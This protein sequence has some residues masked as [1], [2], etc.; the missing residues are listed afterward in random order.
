MKI[1]GND[2]GISENIGVILMVSV[3]VIG[4]AIVS[5]TV[6]SE[7]APEEIPNAD[8]IIGCENA[9]GGTFNVTLYHNGGD[10]LMPDD[11]VV[12]AYD[13][14]DQLIENVTLYEGEST[15]PFAV[16]DTLTFRTDTRPKRISVLYTGGASSAALKSL[17]IGSTVEDDQAAQESASVDTTAS[18][19]ATPTG[20]GEPTPTQTV[21]PGPYP[22]GSAI[23]GDSIWLNGPKKPSILVHGTYIKFRYVQTSAPS[24]ITFTDGTSIVPDNNDIIKIAMEG[25]QTTGKIELAFD[26]VK[27][28]TKGFTAKVYRNNMSV[29]EY[30]GKIST[31]QIQDFT[32]YESTLTLMMPALKEETQLT[33]DGVQII[34]SWPHNTSAIN[35]Y[36][37]GP[38]IGQHAY[39][40]LPGPE[41]EPSQAKVSGYYEIIP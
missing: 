25:T 28:E 10:T 41:G 7:P 21:T 1:R 31:I 27:P 12:R 26:R 2:L 39:V 33:V 15:D 36:N 22:P 37:I 29:P 32:D 14:N 3:V 8:I 4:V 20:G 5:V 6:T 34:T 9:T 18:P 38:I 16:S 24:Y 13:S 35:I 11:L 19:T 30:T 40:Q 17:D 23:Y